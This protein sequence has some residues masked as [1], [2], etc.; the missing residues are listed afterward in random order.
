[1]ESLLMKICPINFGP[2]EEQKPNL[3]FRMIAFIKKNKTKLQS[4]FRIFL[5]LE[6]LALISVASL[7]L[8]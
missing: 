7:W 2:I 3:S 5:T 8:E 1:M 6:E 4:S